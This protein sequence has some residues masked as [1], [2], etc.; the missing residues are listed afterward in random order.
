[1]ELVPDVELKD[2]K[3]LLSLDYLELGILSGMLDL[4][5]LKKTNK[6]LA[7]KIAAAI[8]SA[9]MKHDDFGDQATLE[10]QQYKKLLERSDKNE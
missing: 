8:T 10:I 6:R 5:Q 4:K 2:G 7:I 3:V 1:M 9:Y